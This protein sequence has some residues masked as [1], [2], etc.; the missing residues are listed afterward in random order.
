MPLL[1]KYYGTPYE[2]ISKIAGQLS[3]QVAVPKLG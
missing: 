2:W 1:I 3:D